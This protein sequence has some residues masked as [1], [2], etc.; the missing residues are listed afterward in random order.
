MIGIIVQYIIGFFI[1]AFFVYAG[2]MAIF[3]IK[4]AGM[5]TLVLMWLFAFGGICVLK[6]AQKRRRAIFS[7]KKYKH[8]FSDDFN[9]SI[10]DL[11]D[12]VGENSEDVLENLDF[13]V[14]NNFIDNAY[15]NQK[16]SSIVFKFDNSSSGTTPGENRN[17][18]KD[19]DKDKE[20][21]F[22]AITCKNCGGINKIL[23]G[24][25]GECDFCGSPIQ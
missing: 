25:V 21:E 7:F 4:N 3:D 23:K 10:E 8:Y 14:D 20:P 1:T 19:K 9:G 6:S 17:K 2:V 11:A 22:V 5:F 24:D 18:N 16:S 12:A 13:M 15:I